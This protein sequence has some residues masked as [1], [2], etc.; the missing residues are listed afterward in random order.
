[1]LKHVLMFRLKEKAGGADKSTNLNKLKEALEALKDLIPEI[2]ALETGVNISP[3]PASYDLFYDTEF[4]DQAALE[5]YRTH[6][7]HQK[8]VALINDICMSRVVVDYWA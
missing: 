7:E 2:K 1:M 4:E 3:S 5:S 8:V 6:P